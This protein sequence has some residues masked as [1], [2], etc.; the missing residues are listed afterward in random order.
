MAE[1]DIDTWN[2]GYLAG[3]LLFLLALFVWIMH[4][5]PF[6]EWTRRQFFVHLH[7]FFSHLGGWDWV[8]LASGL[9]VSMILGLF[10]QC[11]VEEIVWRLKERKE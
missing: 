2:L 10:A 4:G 9:L 1:G 11:A 3:G 8:G 6:R 5:L 7:A